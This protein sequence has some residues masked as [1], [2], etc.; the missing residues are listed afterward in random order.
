MHTIGDQVAAWAEDMLGWG[1]GDPLVLTEDQVKF[2]LAFYAVDDTG[3]RFLRTRGVYCRPK[4]YG[5]SPL[6]AIVCAA[7]AHGPV[8]PDGFDAKGFAVGRPRERAEVLMFATEEGQAS[9]TYGPYCD[10][11]VGGALQADAGLDVGFTRTRGRDGSMVMPLSA[12]ATSKDGRRTDFA[13][14]EETHLCFSPQLRDLIATIRRNLAKR[15][16][17]SVELTTAWRPGERSVAELS[18]ELHVAVVEKRV[19]DVGLW[20]DHQEGPEPHDWDNDDEVL[21]CLATAY[22]GCPWVDLDRL[23]MEVRDPTVDRADIERYY[24][25]R[26]VARSDAYVDPAAW[27]ALGGAS[28]PSDGEAVALGFDGSWTDDATALVAVGIESGVAHLI[29]C[30]EAPPGARDWVVDQR[31]VDQAVD[32]AFD[33]WQVEMF[34][35][36]PPRWQD[37][38]AAWQDRYG[39]RVRPWYT[40]RERAMHAAL[41]RL[42]DAIATGSVTHTGNDI[43]ARHL[44][45]ATKRQTRSGGYWIQKPP[46]RPS[47]KID[48]AMALALAWEARA[49][50]L[51]KGWSR[52]RSGKLVAY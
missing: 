12:G 35:P 27:R 48:A 41:E 52:R 1:R 13:T 36:D 44:G 17:R 34:Y 5:K 2:L 6:G 9:N 32:A 18:H 24:L 28:V 33:R 25:N 39:D 4:G 10:L 47:A 40:A 19:P 29:G 46:G 21:A 31:E 51:A 45:N 22:E 3:Q 49:D 8:V 11:V 16:G 7:E 43:L 23:L 20:F 50:V 26:I 37:W 38:V 42:R 15:N 14:F 30:W